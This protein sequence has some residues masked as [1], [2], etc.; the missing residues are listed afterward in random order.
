MDPGGDLETQRKLPAPSETEEWPLLPSKSVIS[1]RKVSTFLAPIAREQSS[2]NCPY[3]A[4][5]SSGH[6]YLVKMAFRP[7]KF[8][9]F[10]APIATPPA[11]LHATP[12]WP[13]KFSVSVNSSAE[14]GPGPA[15]A[16][17]RQRTRVMERRGSNE[18]PSHPCLGTTTTGCHKRRQD[19]C[20]R[21][22]H[23]EE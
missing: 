11:T 7:E 14:F 13:A 17:L 19:S 18:A 6:F 9:L 21:D 20:A 10:L 2:E 16:S 4:I 3:L 8:Q 5:H 23:Q 12:P 1:T 22:P 15:P